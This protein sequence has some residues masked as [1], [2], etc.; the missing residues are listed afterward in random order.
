MGWNKIDKY[1]IHLVNAVLKMYNKT[2]STDC[3][4]KKTVIILYK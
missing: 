1:Y 3:L 2:N 4:L